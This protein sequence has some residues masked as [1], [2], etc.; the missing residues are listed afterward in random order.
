MG[1]ERQGEN[2]SEAALPEKAQLCTG[3]SHTPGNPKY[4]HFSHKGVSGQHT[5]ASTTTDDSYD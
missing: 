4:E 2:L 1:L 3:H 5:T